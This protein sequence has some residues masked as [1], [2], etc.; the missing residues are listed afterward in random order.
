M[1]ASTHHGFE[2][3][4]V[5]KGDRVVTPSTIASGGSFS[6]GPGLRRHLKKGT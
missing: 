6:C 3:T 1:K 5:K 2:V 4:A